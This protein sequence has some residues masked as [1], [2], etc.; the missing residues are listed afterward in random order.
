[1]K[2]FITLLSTAFLLLA[3]GCSK[4][5]NEA[6]VGTLKQV[7]ELKKT[8]S[9]GWYL[10]FKGKIEYSDGTVFD[11]KEEKTVALPERLSGRIWSEEMQTLGPGGERSYYIQF[12]P[13]GYELLL[14][15]GSS[16]MFFR[17]DLA[18]HSCRANW[19]M[20]CCVTVTYNDVT[21]Y[22]GSYGTSAFDPILGEFPALGTGGNISPGQTG[23]LCSQFSN[24]VT[25]AFDDDAD[26][27]EIRLRVSNN[28]FLYQSRIILSALISQVRS[29]NIACE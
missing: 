16:V 12:L 23:T 11:S 20:R 24:E 7:D 22:G 5:P 6:V 1:M 9:E 26:I 10:T 13:D 18:V 19:A 4:N 2:N 25:V 21:Q 15:A 14:F 29:R 28:Q 3:F 8:A 17:N 27:N